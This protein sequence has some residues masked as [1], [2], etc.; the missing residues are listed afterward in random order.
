MTNLP[1]PFQTALTESLHEIGDSGPILELKPQGGG[2]INHASQLVTKQNKYFLK[3]NNQ[4]LPDM[5][6]TE[7][8]GLQLLSSA[9]VIRVPT[10]IKAQEPKAG[11]PAFILLEWI[12]R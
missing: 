7:A 2:C 6:S 3:W 5:F 8:K 10:V 1:N 12:E 11:V 9:E 4:P